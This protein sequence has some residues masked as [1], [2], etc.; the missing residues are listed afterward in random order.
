[1][2]GREFYTQEKMTGL[3]WE[4]ERW[5]KMPS[6]LPALGKQL[7]EIMWPGPGTTSVRCLSESF[8]NLTLAINQVQHRNF[9]LTQKWV[10]EMFSLWRQQSRHL[11][12]NKSGNW[13]FDYMSGYFE[14]THVTYIIY[15]SVTVTLHLLKIHLFRLPNITSFLTRSLVSQI[16]PIP[17]AP[18]K[19]LST[20]NF[21]PWYLFGPRLSSFVQVLRLYTATV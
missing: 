16:P 7:S 17:P 20:L 2:E 12:S 13:V 14:G 5:F 10:S 8:C 11:K 4:Q 3:V 9:F 1:M 18:Q 21:L 15:I 19:Y 6:I